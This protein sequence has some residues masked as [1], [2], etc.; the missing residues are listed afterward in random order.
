[1]EARRY[2]HLRRDVVE[3][4]TWPHPVPRPEKHE[5][6]ARLVARSIVEG[7]RPELRLTLEIVDAQ[8]DRANPEHRAGLYPSS[9]NGQYGAPTNAPARRSLRSALHRSRSEERRGGKEG[10]HGEGR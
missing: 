8:H 4:E 2:L 10:N 6:V 9:E 3:R 7:G 5:V 1:M